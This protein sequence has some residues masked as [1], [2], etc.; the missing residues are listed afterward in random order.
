MAELEQVLYAQM[1]IL[2]APQAVPVVAHVPLLLTTL[3]SRQPAL[4][5]AAADTLRHLAG[6]LS[7]GKPTD[8]LGV[9]NPQS[10]SVPPAAR[11]GC[12]SSIMLERSLRESA[13]IFCSYLLF[14][15]F[16]SQISHILSAHTVGAVRWLLW[17][18]LHAEWPRIR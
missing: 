16:S 18:A 13:V 6:A 8:A 1:L 2:F 5:K 3:A 15:G 17:E 4:R 14:R 11:A 12:T 10:G 9:S 7:C